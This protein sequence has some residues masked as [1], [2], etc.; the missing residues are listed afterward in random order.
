MTTEI[1]GGTHGRYA[2]TN[3]AYRAFR[4]TFPAGV[5][6]FCDADNGNEVVAVLGTMNVIRNLFPY[7]VWDSAVVEDHLMI[8]P[9]R[10]VLSLDEYT[11]GEGLD[12]LALVR[13]YEAA[14]YAIYSRAPQSLSRSVGHVH[15]HLI[16]TG[17]FLG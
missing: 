3:D 12:F 11:D 1:V 15:T 14:G 5:C 10:H 8:V 17:R 4:A 16:K 13:R 9:A 6:A 2:E 7:A